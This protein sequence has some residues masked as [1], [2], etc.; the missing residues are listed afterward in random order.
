MFDRRKSQGVR[1][2]AFLYK[3]TH[4]PT[5]KWYVGSRSAIGCHIN[6]GYI[7]SSDTVFP[8]ITENKE[9]W[10]REILVIGNPVYIRELEFEYLSAINAAS[11]SMSFN[12][13]NGFGSYVLTERI[14]SEET[15]RKISNSLFGKKQSQETRMKKSKVF[16]GEGNPFFGKTHSEET[17]N[18]LRQI[19]LGKTRPDSVKDKI[20]ETMTGTIRPDSVKAAISRGVSLLERKICEYCNKSAPPATFGRWHGERCKL[21]KQYE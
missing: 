18:Y 11:D 10:R 3:W 4:I 13:S 8:M 5:Q 12:K 19:N 17:R 21:R 14:H 20:S 9:E 1:T 15:K 6:D 2:E 16:S 7:C